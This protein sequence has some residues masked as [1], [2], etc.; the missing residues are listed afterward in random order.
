MRLWRSSIYNI[1][2]G[3]LQILIYIILSLDNGHIIL[4]IN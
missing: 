4:C 1:A 3:Y 2:Y